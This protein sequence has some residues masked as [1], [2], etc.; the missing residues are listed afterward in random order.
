MK[1]ERAS[2]KKDPS[3][4]TNV[5]Y[6]ER[7]SKRHQ[8]RLALSQYKFQGIFRRPAINEPVFSRKRPL[9]TIQKKDV[10]TSS[11]RKKEPNLDEYQAFQKLPP[12]EKERTRRVYDTY[13]PLGYDLKYCISL[14]KDQLRD[15]EK[16]EEQRIDERNN[17]ERRLRAQR[18]AES[19]S[20]LK[21]IFQRF[22]AKNQKVLCTVI[23]AAP[24]K[25][26]MDVSE[27][28]FMFTTSKGL[29]VVGKNWEHQ[30]KKCYTKEEDEKYKDK[31]KVLRTQLESKEL[32]KEEV[33]DLI[34]RDMKKE[35]IK[36]P[37]TV[38]KGRKWYVFPRIIDLKV[39]FISCQ[40]EKS[41]LVIQ[42]EGG[43]EL[44]VFGFLGR[45]LPNITENGE[46]KCVLSLPFQERRVKKVEAGLNSVMFLLS[47][48][49]VVGFGDNSYGQLGKL[50]HKGKSDYISEILELK[51]LGSSN[52]DICCALNL[53]VIFQ[54]VPGKP[55]LV[56]FFLGG[57]A[58]NRKRV[59][60]SLEKGEQLQSAVC[61]RSHVVV[62]LTS[63]RILTLGNFFHGQLGNMLL[64]NKALH[65]IQK[66]II[67]KPYIL[68]QKMTPI[69]RKKIILVGAL[70]NGTILLT[71]TR[72]I[73]A[74]G[75]V[76]NRIHSF[77]TLVFEL[78]D[79]VLDDIEYNLNLY[80]KDHT[81][82][83]VK[84]RLN[85]SRFTAISCS[86]EAFCVELE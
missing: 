48:G 2:P 71:E 49:K 68:N 80:D 7:R 61:G 65:S 15:E 55:N 73:Y 60:V 26:Q 72:E 36:Y 40:S 24:S 62:L 66:E 79:R 59:K 34:A 45:I 52:I 9:P 58:L 10:G 64:I 85:H 1:R 30:L 44:H 12:D 47:S 67:L 77:P 31:V 82:A 46:R 16:A 5:A 21:L 74:C 11:K 25:S 29:A 35:N 8:N 42:K 76:L 28:H 78:S 23:E 57:G 32:K 86:E 63:G 50:K 39:S 3:L 22:G 14:A 27:S 53:S 37:L 70:Q 41:F 69:G 17:E 51:D 54:K 19:F 38:Y 43:L 81:L 83:I 18:I 84:K 4:W 13:Q 20:H 6:L 56:L 75:N 33:E